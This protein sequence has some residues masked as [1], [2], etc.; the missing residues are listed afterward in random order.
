MTK[1]CEGLHLQV[2]IIFSYN[3]NLLTM[4]N[5]KNLQKEFACGQKLSV[6]EMSSIKGGVNA[7]ASAN[8]LAHANSVVTGTADDKRRERPGGGIG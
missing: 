3:F 7:N 4:M 8:G 5:L 2:L 6:N 1:N